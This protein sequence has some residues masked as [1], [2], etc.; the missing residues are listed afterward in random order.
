MAKGLKKYFP[1][2]QTKG[3]ILQEIRQKQQLNDLFNNCT[4]PLARRLAPGTWHHHFFLEKFIFL[5][6]TVAVFEF[7]VYC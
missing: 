4:K 6:I 5:K 3:A 1:M 7:M 2:I